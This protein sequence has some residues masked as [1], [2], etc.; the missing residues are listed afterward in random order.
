MALAKG[1]RNSESIQ[2]I[3]DCKNE[4]LLNITLGSLVRP[5]VSLTAPNRDH[6]ARVSLTFF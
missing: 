3:V 6:F 1:R 5:Q 2:Q 4:H